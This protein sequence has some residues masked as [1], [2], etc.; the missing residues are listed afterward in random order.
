MNDDARLSRRGFVGAGAGT[1]AVA[2]WGAPGALARRDD[3]GGRGR[4]SRLLPRRRIGIQLFTVRDHVAALGFEAVF[5][6]LSQIGYREV[7][8]AGYSAQGR[9]WTNEELRRLLRRYGLKGVGSHVNYF[10]ADPNAYSFVTQLE[11]VLDDAEEIGLPYIGTASSPGARYGETVEGYRRA[12]EDFNRFGAAARA[13]GMRFYQ[14]N[15]SGEF[16]IE[17]GTRLYDVILAETDPRLVFFEL[18]I[19]WAYVGQSRFPGFKPHEYPWS[20]P[21]RFPLFHVK[22]GIDYSNVP[23]VTGQFFDWDMTDVGDGDIAFE[24]FFCGLDTKRH[25]YLVERDTAPDPVR[26][27]AGSFSTAERSYAYL[28][29]LRERRGGRARRG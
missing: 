20:M 17:N 22:D 24:P 3:S 10:S 16:A 18:D 5:A 14:H 11:Q 19:F 25:H 21:E 12:A 26:N 8:F 1:A 7:E 4:G 29:R 28:A 15:H 23:A 27:P 13:R 9:R 2:A 6:R